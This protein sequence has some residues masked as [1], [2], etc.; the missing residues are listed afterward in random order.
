KKYDFSKGVRGK[1]LKRYRAGTNVVVLDP[2]VSGVFPDSRSV[3]RTLR[4]VA[5]ILRELHPRRSSKGSR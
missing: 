5:Q 3:N 2:D 1:Y 4:S